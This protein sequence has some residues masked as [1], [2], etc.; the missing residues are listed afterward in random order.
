MMKTSARF[1]TL[2]ALATATV[3][4]PAQTQSPASSRRA[5]GLQNLLEAEL[6]RFPARTGVWVKNLTTGEEAAVRAD[7]TFNTASVIKIPVLVLAMQMADKAQL[8]LGDRYTITAADVRGGSGIFRMNDPGLQ[9]TLRDVL[10]Q[11]VITSDNTATDIA[12][13]KVGGVA[14]VNA[15]LKASGYGNEMKLGMTT[16]ELFAKYA[17]L[18]PGAN[19]DDKTNND[20]SYWLGEMTPRATGRMLESIQRCSDG[21]ATVPYIAEK[22]SCALM[23]RMLRGQQAGAR[24]LP[25]YLSVSVAHKTG[26]FPPVLANDVGIIFARAGPIVVSFFANAIDGPFAEAEDRIG[27]IAQLIVEYFD[28]L[29]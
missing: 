29:R 11:M 6:A 17:A 7:D 14:R 4:Q 8:T 15:W 12:I 22:T 5:N 25:H 23:M 28:G 19:S 1:I 3:P 26:D 16:G 20:H 21:S 13:A 18:A 27:R 9:P 10:L 24:R 2:F